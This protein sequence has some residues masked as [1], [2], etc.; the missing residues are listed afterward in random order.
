MSD[1]SNLGHLPDVPDDD[2]DEG[3]LSV[4]G[5][6]CD[7]VMKTSEPIWLNKD[8]GEAYTGKGK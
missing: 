5:A 7:H 1:V 2:I 3:F 4:S 6:F 8:K